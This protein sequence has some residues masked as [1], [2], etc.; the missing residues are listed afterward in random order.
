MQILI[1]HQAT[2]QQLAAIRQLIP[3]AQIILAR[4]DAE[5][6]QAMPAADVIWGSRYL[7][8][9]LPLAGRLQ[10]IQVSSAG[11]ERLLV[12]ELLAHP[13]ALAN[14][15]GIH[16]ATIAEHVFMLM[17][18]LARELPAV[19][20]AASRREWIRP[21]PVLLNGQTLGIV[22][23]GSIG[24]AIAARAKAFGMRVIAT[25]RHAAPDQWADQV[26]SDQQLPQLLAESDYVVLATPLTQETLHLIGEEQLKLMKPTACLINIAR[27]QVVDEPALIRCLQNRGIR[28]AGL[29]VFEQEPLPADSPLWAM[30]NVIVTPHLAGSMPDYDDQAFA[31]FLEN[32]RRLQA[33]QPLINLVDKQAG[34]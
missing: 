1:T 3:A 29:D 20:Q 13:T 24:Q 5:I 21:N 10:L 18:A 23:Y 17:L 15:R 6:R 30:E 16:G 27:G 4:E 22:G 14:A 12:P 19:L 33:N 8:D 2:E 11:V 28:A 26:W 7:A 9:A 34:Y 25:R 31:I 32:L